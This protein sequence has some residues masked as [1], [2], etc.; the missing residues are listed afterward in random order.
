MGDGFHSF[1]IQNT[2]KLCKQCLEKPASSIKQLSY[3]LLNLTFRDS[4]SPTVFPNTLRG[5]GNGDIQGPALGKLAQLLLGELLF[6]RICSW[7]PIQVP[8]SVLRYNGQFRQFNCF[9]TSK[10]KYDGSCIFELKFKVLGSV[11]AYIGIF[12]SE[13]SGNVWIMCSGSIWAKL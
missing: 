2:R 11:F 5:D 6:R 3:N 8:Q 13:S 1:K 10:C 9:S 7:E 4:C 12:P